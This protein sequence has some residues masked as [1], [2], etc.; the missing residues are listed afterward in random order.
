M[1]K[2]ETGQIA[3]KLN[4]R[5]KKVI[6]DDGPSGCNSTSLFPLRHV[7]ES[8]P[9]GVETM[10]TLA[11]LS[12]DDLVRAVAHRWTLLSRQ[13]KQTIEF[14]Q[15]SRAVGIDGGH[16][17]GAITGVAFELAMDISGFIG[18]LEC[19]TI[20]APTF[21]QQATAKGTALREQFFKAVAFW[22]GTTSGQVCEPVSLA[23]ALGRRGMSMRI[24]R[25]ARVV[26]EEERRRCAEIAAFRKEWRLSQSQ[27][28]RLFI[29][30][31]RTVRHWERGEFSPTPQQQRFLGLLAGY[32]R[33]EGLRAFHKRFV[34]EQA[35]RYGQPGRPA[36]TP[37]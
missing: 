35:P 36:G 37:R 1:A 13:A 25:G 34:G 23:R 21:P 14:E 2:S 4:P 28:A 16:F 17:F 6:S 3:A 7:A 29:S 20:Q 10:V 8:I 11:S 33:R 5:I 31:T 18:S 27:F 15:L 19:W 30:S 22:A 12:R 26:S 9:G 32:A 24:G